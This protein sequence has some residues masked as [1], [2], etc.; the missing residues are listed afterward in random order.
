L[1]DE[2]ADFGELSGV[3]V[4]SVTDTARPML[5]RRVYRHQDRHGLD[6]RQ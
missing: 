3:G 6:L 5:H 4:G 1:V 2:P